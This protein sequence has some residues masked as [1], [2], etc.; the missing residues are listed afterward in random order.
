VHQKPLGTDHLILCNTLEYIGMVL[1]D[2]S[3]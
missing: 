1:E 3:V 2:P